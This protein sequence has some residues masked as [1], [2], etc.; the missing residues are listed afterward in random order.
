VRPPYSPGI[1]NLILVALAVLLV[2]TG[3]AVAWVAAHPDG[4]RRVVHRLGEWP[5][6]L[7]LRSRYHRWIVFLVRRFQPRGAY[8]LSFTI[9]LAVLALSTRAFGGVLE[10]VLVREEIALFAIAPVG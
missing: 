8:G 3:A 4:V 10:D 9:G 5:P 1:A 6:L 7:R 2:A